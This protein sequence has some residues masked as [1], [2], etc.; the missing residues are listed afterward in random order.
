MGIVL[1][2]LTVACVGFVTHVN[3]MLYGTPPAGVVRGKEDR[4]RL[5]PLALC[6]ASLVTLGLFVPAPVA[7]LLAQIAEI[8]GP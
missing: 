5:V 3:R 8:V 1:A 4:W 7:S 2:L 6:M